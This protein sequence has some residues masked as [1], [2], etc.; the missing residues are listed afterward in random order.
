M[1][2]ALPVVFRKPGAEVSAFFTSLP[3]L[4]FR[5]KTQRWG[6]FAFNPN[7]IHNFSFTEGN[8][9]LTGGLR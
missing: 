2:P 1:G 3:M 7:R 8:Y 6:F 5:D 9:L 4:T